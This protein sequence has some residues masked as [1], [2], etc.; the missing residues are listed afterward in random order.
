MHPSFQLVIAPRAL[1]SSIVA[2]QR[3]TVIQSNYEYYQAKVRRGNFHKQCL[4]YSDQNGRDM[5]RDCYY[6][7]NTA[8]EQEDLQHE[9]FPSLV[10]W[11][12]SMRHNTK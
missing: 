6:S 8:V 5:Q 9:I 2:P 11:T 7:N 1:A 3:C 12:R 10:I 4:E